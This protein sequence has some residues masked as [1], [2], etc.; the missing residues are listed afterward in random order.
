[1]IAEEAAVVV[2]SAVSHL[3]NREEMLPRFAPGEM[4]TPPAPRGG[5]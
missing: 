4:P 5:Q 3:A 2:A 1:V